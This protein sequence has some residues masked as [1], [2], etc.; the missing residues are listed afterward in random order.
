MC[1]PHSGAP[2][3]LRLLEEVVP[4]S[5]ERPAS[6]SECLGVPSAHHTKRGDDPLR[7]ALLSPIFHSELVRVSRGSTGYLALLNHPSP[8]WF[9]AEAWAG[10]LLGTLPRPYA[11]P[12]AI[13]Q[14][15]L[16]SPRNPVF[17]RLASSGQAA[18]GTFLPRVPARLCPCSLS[19]FPR[20][21]VPGTDL[22]P[23]WWPPGR[24]GLSQGD[25]SRAGGGSA[26]KARK[27][28]CLLPLGLGGQGC[29]SR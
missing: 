20:Y 16:W 7:Q 17:V 26:G 8:A 9:G 29:P 2:G 28:I 13:L 22:T 21:S 19:H 18:G 25:P 4:G 14:V 23:A 5:Q 15:H 10:T 11:L 1:A 27:D 12:R 24:P 6:F 3:D